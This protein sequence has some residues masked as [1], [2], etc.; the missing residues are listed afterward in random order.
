M[1]PANSATTLLASTLAIVCIL[2]ST[3]HAETPGIL[4]N[5][6]GQI[7]KEYDI[8]AFTQRNPNQQNPEQAIVDW[9]MRE[10]GTEIWFVEPLG[11]LSA[12]RQKLTVYHTPEIQAAVSEIVE[13]FVR[14]ETDTHVFS[15][16]MVSVDSANWRTKMLTRL[17]PVAVQSPGVEAWLVNREDAAMMV[18]ELRKRTDFREYSSPNV[19]IRNGQS[20][21]VERRR[22]IAYIKSIYENPAL[23]GNYQQE[24][25]QV[26]EGFALALSP[27]LTI[28]KRAVD[29]VLKMDASQL[30]QLTNISV[31]T[32]SATNPRQMSQVQVP[33]TSSWR[34]HERFRWPVDQVLLISC[35]VVPRPSPTD[36]G[37][38]GLR[39][40][41]KRGPPRSDALI[42]V[43]SKGRITD[44]A[45]SPQG[46]ERY[47][48]PNFR[49][50]Y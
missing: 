32:A 25:G 49:G 44:V 38:L 29:A 45:A 3:S 12:N 9:I 7:W 41:V 30:E 15:V 33:Q 37:P 1:T 27:L 16:R 28:D 46:E 40:I 18:D 35:G 10:T 39:A 48:G 14:P 4:P 11:L 6:H 8:R 47:E 19:L 5:E 24:M 36:G 34:L 50:R 42:F 17:R 26:E 21:T 43:E 2:L 22:P 20:H 13:R 23:A 31:P